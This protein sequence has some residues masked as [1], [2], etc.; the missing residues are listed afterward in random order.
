MKSI[1]TNNPLMVNCKKILK[2]YELYLFILPAIVWYAIFAYGPLYGLQIAFKDFNGALGIWGSKWVG[3]KH[4]ESFAN[5]YYFWHLIKNTLLV[6][7]YSL[8]VG[9]PIPIILSLMLNEVRQ[10][11]YKKFVQTVIYAPHFIS[12]VVLVGMLF[13]FLSPSQGIV[14]FALEALGF[15]AKSFMTDQYAFRHIYVWSGV[16]QNSGWGTI[17]YLAAL[18]GVSPDLHESSVIDGANR[19]QRIWYINIPAII[20]TIVII[21][22][23]N[24]GSIMNVGFEKTFLMQND[25][26][27]DTSEVI[28]TY[29]YKRGLINANFS[30]SAA[31]GLF[32]NVINFILLIIVNAISRKLNETSLF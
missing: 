23:L 18:S 13:I 27:L 4:L 1:R 6:S 10:L 24:V 30:F 3:L 17:I 8:T 20:P 26:N 19:L 31:V 22:I 2:D 11:K 16:W 7:F 12:I 21:L 14:N 32:N 25:L 28:A 9:F 5:S 15:D 29:I